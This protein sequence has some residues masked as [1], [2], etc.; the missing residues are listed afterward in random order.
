MNMDCIL[1]KLMRILNIQSIYPLSDFHYLIEGKKFISPS[2]SEGRSSST[3]N[4]ACFWKVEWYFVF[5]CLDNFNAGPRN[6]SSWPEVLGAVGET[7]SLSFTDFLTLGGEVGFDW[8]PIALDPE[9]SPRVP[10]SDDVYSPDPP[11]ANIGLDCFADFLTMKVR[12]F[13]IFLFPLFPRD[14]KGE[15]SDYSPGYRCSGLARVEWRC[16]GFRKSTLGSI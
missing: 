15:S 12:W 1:V 13:T 3:S 5:V 2:S 7:I 16:D 6:Y 11:A 14:T 9:S 10:S 4:L 8:R